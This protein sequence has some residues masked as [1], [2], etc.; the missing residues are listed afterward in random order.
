ML[1]ISVVLPKPKTRTGFGFGKGSIFCV[2]ATL[3]FAAN[4]SLSLLLRRGMEGG[5]RSGGAQHLLD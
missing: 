3:Y 4:L 2:P 5:G 1:Q